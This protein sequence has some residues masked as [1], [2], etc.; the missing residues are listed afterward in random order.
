MNRWLGLAGLACLAV[1][2]VQAKTQGAQEMRYEANWASIDKRPTPQWWVDA[3]LG[4]FIHWGVYSVPAWS[5]RG[6][7]SEWYWN[8]ITG[9]KAK[10]GPWWQYHAKTYGANFP[11]AGFAPMFKAELYDPNQ[12][13]DIFAR[14]GARYVVVT[15]KHHD[16]YCMWPSQEANRS[17]GRPWNSADIGPGRDLL[18]ELTTAVRARGIHMGIY[19]SLYEWYNPLWVTDRPLYV[20]KH[21]FPQFKDVVTRYHP[22]VIFSDGEWDMPSKDWRSEELLAWLFN[23]SPVKDNVV[24]NDRWGKDCRHKHGGYYTTE[25]T[26]G[27]ASGAHPWEE[28]R[29]MGHSYGYSRT[30]P[31]ADY[32]SARELVLMLIDIVSRGGNLLLDI[33]PAADGTIPV[34]MEER[35]TQI[36]EWLKVNGEAI[37]GT[38]NWNRTTQWTEG[39]RPEVGYGK[40]FMAKY[41]INEL[42]SKPTADKAVIE[43]FFTTKGD[44]LYVIT[45]RWPGEKLVMKDIE[46]SPNTVVTML[47]VA[48]SIRWDRSGSDLTIHVPAMSVDDVPCRYAYVFKVTGVR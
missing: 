16:G 15:S 33:G 3:K 40:E 32:R 37:Y 26:A 34:I 39:K 12:W 1:M 6:Q 47:G 48:Q 24:I 28:S 44:T 20:E 8:R 22:E 11:Y 36:G 38:R 41:D 27:L 4:I 25:Y 42:T 45:P 10:N 14:S 23:E 31:L 43:A 2:C 5:V 9:D 18:G 7:Y 46:V 35:L 17:W 29:G 13:A 30:E 19:Y 21:M